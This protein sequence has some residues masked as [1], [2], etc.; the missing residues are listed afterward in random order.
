MLLRFVPFTGANLALHPLLLPE[1]VGV[2]A[3]NMNVERGD[4]RPIKAATDVADVVSDAVSIYRM[5]R[6]APSD[7]TYWLGWDVDVDVARGFVAEDT[8]ERTFWSGD[9]VP[10][11]T[12]NSI[13]LGAPPYPDSSGVRILGVPKP[14]ATPSLTETVAGSGTDETRAYVV[15]WVNDRGEESQPSNAATITCKPGATIRVTRNA[16][17]PSGAYGLATW[18]VYRTVSGNN[19]DYFYV[20][21]TTAATAT[22]DTTDATLNTASA[23]QT[24]GW[25]MPPSNLKGLKTLWNGI[26]VGFYGKALCFSE[27]LYPYAWPVAYQIPLDADIVGLARVGLWLIVLTVDQPY[28]VTGSSPSAMTA[29]VVEFKQ[30]CVAKRGIVELGHG[31]AWPSPDGLCYIGGDGSRR[32]LTEDVA[33]RTDWQALNPETLIAGENEGEYLGSY[34][35]GAGRKS[36]ALDPMKP[37][38]G[39]RFCDVGWLACYRDPIGDAFYILDTAADGDVLK[40]DAGTA[41]TASFKSRVERVAK[42]TCFVVGQVVADAYPVTLSLW[43]NGSAVLTNYSVASRASFKL[44]AGFW[45]DQW[46]MK[47]SS[48]GAVQMVLLAHSVEELNRA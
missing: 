16:T 18:R 26:M 47:I 28:L 38:A 10:K 17:V 31:V 32:V 1:G 44:P 43:A 22:L 48:T 46:Q 23:L 19:D 27:P 45:A 12:D 33:T 8:S 42:P 40:W 37:G 5:G 35:P 3:N 34:N 36:F 30:A 21:E 39:F 7:S 20:G 25:D 11:W 4:L 41:L 2:E 14:N 24:E 15:T 13:G 29:Q 9:G 6:T